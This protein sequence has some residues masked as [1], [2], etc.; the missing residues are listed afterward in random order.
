M[1]SRRKPN[2]L[3]GL[4]YS[5]DGRYFFTS[6]GNDEVR[7]G[8]M[9]LNEYGKIAQEHWFWPVE[10]YQTYLSGSLLNL[11][12]NGRFMAGSYGARESLIE[13]SDTFTTNPP[14]GRKPFLLPYP[15]NYHDHHLPRI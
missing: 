7:Y 2:L 13:F 12:G 11:P 10:Q 15:C 6:V 5:R 14:N 1:K 8:A 9:P 4:D 3:P